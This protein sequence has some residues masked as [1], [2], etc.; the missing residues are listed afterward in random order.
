[1]GD[2]EKEISPAQ[3]EN[4]S[5]T[6]IQNGSVDKSTVECERAQLLSNLPDPDAGKTDEE[7]KAIVSNEHTHSQKKC[8]K[9]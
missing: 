2:S 9:K 6:D 1:M 3:A 7:R 5:W 8:G 4:G